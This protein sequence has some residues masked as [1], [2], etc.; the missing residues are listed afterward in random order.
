MKVTFEQTSI[1]FT[2]EKQFIILGASCSRKWVK[3]WDV[4]YITSLMPN[5]LGITECCALNCK[6]AK[7]QYSDQNFASSFN[8]TILNG[9]QQMILVHIQRA[10]LVASFKNGIKH[11]HFSTTVTIAPKTLLIHLICFLL[12]QISHFPAFTAQEKSRSPKQF[13]LYTQVL[14]SCIKINF[15][16]VSFYLCVGDLYLCTYLVDSQ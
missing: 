3:L 10:S 15:T 14:Y 4:Y 11:L 12:R 9:A 8:R 5:L 16:L 13:V 7:I 1:P 2:A 6:M